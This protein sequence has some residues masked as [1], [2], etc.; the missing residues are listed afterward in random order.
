MK[1]G[2]GWK[3]MAG[4]VIVGLV[5]VVAL[6]NGDPGGV[7]V[8]G[9][10][11]PSHSGPRL[12]PRRRPAPVPTLPG[13]PDA[14]TAP[15][16]R[17]PGR[18]HRGPPDPRHVRPAQRRRG[19]RAG[20]QRAPGRLGA[21]LQRVAEDQVTRR[22]LRIDTYQG[23]VDT[24]FF[25]LNRTDA[26]VRSGAEFPGPAYVRDIIEKD[27]KAV[28][29]NKPNTLYAVYYD[30][31]SDYSCGGGAWPPEL[32]GTVG[33]MYLLGLPNASVTC[34]S[35][36]L[37]GANPD[38]PWYFDFGMLHELVH[39]MG[40]NPTCAPTRAPGRTRPTR[41]T[42]CTAGARR[43]TSTTSGS[44]RGTTTGTG[45][46]TPA[47]STSTTVPACGGRSPPTATST[48][49]AAPTSPCTGRRPGRGTATAG[50]PPRSVWPATSPSP[51]TTTATAPPT[52]PC[53]GP[54]SAA[55]T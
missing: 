53:S 31:H 39:S 30:G 38:S 7:A 21:R 37:P 10:P 6:R 22:E 34:A 1:L 8:T 13:R 36:G 12:P 47:A 2:H 16:H 25:R 20:H 18:R 28:G 48:A 26:E 49:T 4:A 41:P 44:T 14:R 17:R 9:A 23:A 33:A 11:P 24:S 55:G 54:R 42:S 40:F 3:L 32:V 50:R 46:A 27:M 19:P 29:F 15:Q 52:S 45:T 43:G 5:G 35:A 51:A